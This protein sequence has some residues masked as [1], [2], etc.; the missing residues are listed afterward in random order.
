MLSTAG[1]LA[2][3][4]RFEAVDST[5]T[6]YAEARRGTQE[7][8]E[9]GFWRALYKLDPRNPSPQPVTAMQLLD[10]YMLSGSVHWYRP[11]ARVVRELAFVQAGA[12]QP[13]TAQ[14]VQASPG[15]G[16]RP[17][18]NAEK[19]IEIQQLRE[20]NARLE[21]ELERIRRRLSTP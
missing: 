15:T 6:A 13:V 9:V 16:P 5:L 18:T 17:T 10:D 7:A 2:E 19:D 4:G 3:A 1:Q 12:A 14:P 21:A 8:H 11:E 20:R